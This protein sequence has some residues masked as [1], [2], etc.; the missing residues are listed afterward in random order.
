MTKKQWTIQPNMVTETTKPKEVTELATA[1][2][3]G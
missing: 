2:V 1:G 3:E